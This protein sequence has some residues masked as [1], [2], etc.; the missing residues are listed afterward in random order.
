MSAE[1]EHWDDCPRC[2]YEIKLKEVERGERCAQCFT[3][4]VAAWPVEDPEHPG[5]CRPCG[6]VQ[7]TKV[8]RG[9]SYGAGRYRDA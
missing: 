1:T 4:L 7:D 8:E 6:S 2:M 3:T 5:F 9:P